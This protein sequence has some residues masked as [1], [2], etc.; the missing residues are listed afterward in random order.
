MS[1]SLGASYKND[2]SGKF[3]NNGY[4]VLKWQEPPENGQQVFLKAIPEAIKFN[5]DKHTGN[6]KNKDPG[7]KYKMF[8]R[9]DSSINNVVSVKEKEDKEK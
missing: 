6:D 3:G 9:P 2:S 7:R 8:I 1:S 4:P 5:V